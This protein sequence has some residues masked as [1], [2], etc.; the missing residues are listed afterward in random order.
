MTPTQSTL[1]PVEFNSGPV[2]AS[3]PVEPD[4]PTACQQVGDFVEVLFEP[5]DIIEVRQLPSGRS[6]WH[7][8]SELSTPAVVAG[9][10]RDNTADQHIYIGAN[11]RRTDGGRKAEDV[12]LARCLFADFDGVTL[13]EVRRRIEGL[14]EPTV[15]I[16]SGHGI[17]AYWRLTEPIHDMVAWTQ[18]QKDLIALV[19]SDPTIHDPPRIMRLPGFTNHKTPAALAELVEAHP[20]R[21]YD[22]AD[23][24]GCFPHQDVTETAVEATPPQTTVTP[25]T[26]LEGIQRATAWLLKRPGAV[27][28]QNGDNH[29]F[30]TCSSLVRDFALS[31]DVAWS[32]LQPWNRTCSPPWDEADLRAKLTNATKY[33]KHQEGQKLHERK[34]IA[35]PTDSAPE[36]AGPPWYT[37]SDISKRPEYREGLNPISTGFPSVDNILSGGWRP[38]CTYIIAGR[39]G[40]AKSTLACNI[41][42]YVALD[43][44]PVLLVKL[45][46][47]LEEVAWRIHSAASRLDLRAFLNGQQHTVQADVDDGYGLLQDLPIRISDERRIDRIERIVRQHAEAGGK[48]VVIDQI[49]MVDVPGAKNIYEQITYA[50]N[51]FR[52]LAKETRLPIVVVCQI[53]RP[54][55]KNEKALSCHD[56]RDSGAIENDA[57][58]VILINRV[59]EPDAPRYHTDPL[60]LE[61]LIDKN[62]YGKRTDP[63]NPLLLQW[64]PSFC[65]IQDARG[66]SRGCVA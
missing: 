23:L 22:L 21:R 57:A 25:A 40:G 9:L 3:M 35:Q 44:N 64:W 51:R 59:C 6:T 52:V 53:N 15:I 34:H 46:E 63:E 24:H 26:D 48:L 54:A 13:D 43:D 42:R 8:A 28:G 12:P 2:I 55:A 27:E 30:A 19:D 16:G 66:P 65:R 1:E 47:P 20:E 56:L 32:L 58:A 18:W 50:S 4:A 62:R 38:R 7:A 33:A 10:I 14:P 11:P 41:V 31:E 60:S 37:W 17:H 61:I 39:T 36:E 5:S 29:T 45:E 49:S